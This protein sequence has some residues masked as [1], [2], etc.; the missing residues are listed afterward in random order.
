M[1]VK[2]NSQG[3]IIQMMETYDYDDYAKK[4]ASCYNPEEN[5][6]PRPPPSESLD[7][8]GLCKAFFTARVNKHC[9]ELSQY[10]T[11]DFVLNDGGYEE[12]LSE[13]I[14]LCQ[15]NSS[16]YTVSDQL[17]F[18]FNKTQA[19][20]SD[21]FS[22]VCLDQHG[23]LYPYMGPEFISCTAEETDKGLKLNRAVC[24]YDVQGYMD[25]ASHCVGG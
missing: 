20:I 24:A 3:K 17:A 18:K 21:V 4:I 1:V 12:S 16:A 2:L 14:A 13:A 9:E 11:S 8:L 25:F 10:V 15:S 23:Q 5:S 19:H 6:R 22:L 7:V